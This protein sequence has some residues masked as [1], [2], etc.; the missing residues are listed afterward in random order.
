MLV[1]VRLTLYNIVAGL[2][3]GPTLNLRE[4]SLEEMSI[5]RKLTTVCCAAV[6]ALGL[7]ACSSSNNDTQMG[8][9]KPP[10]PPAD[11]TLLFA[12]AQDAGDAAMGAGDD[13]TAAEKAAMDNTDEYDTMRVAGDSSVAM[14]NARA[15]LDAQ[16]D[17]GQ[18]VMDAQT[19]LVDANQAK[20][21]AEDIDDEHPQKA[22]LDA[23]I[24]EA[25]AAADKAL[26]AATDIHDGDIVND[27]V[28]GVTGGED[29]DPPGTARSIANK[30]GMD[31]AMAL[32]PNA[33]G[34]GARLMADEEM[35]PVEED[36]V[37]EALMVMMDDRVGMTWAEIVG[38]TVKMRIAKD[39][40]NTNEVDA[41]S[42]AGMTLA[43]TRD[44]TD[45][46]MKEANGVQVGAAY[47]GI[48]GTAFCVGSNC[49][50][51]ADAD[52]GRKFTG[53]WYFT[54]A[55]PMQ[56]YLKNADGVYGPETLFVSFGHWL[57]V[58]EAAGDEWTVHT[59]A[60]STAAT[61][62]TVALSDDLDDSATYNG[63]AAGM[64]VY[65]TDN[66]AG[67]GQDINS[68]R[69]TAD[70]TLN[71]EFGIATRTAAMIGGTIDGFDGGYAAND[72]WSVRLVEVELK[73]DG[74]P[75][76]GK[77]VTASDDGVWSAA[78]YGGD[79]AA[80]PAGV[81]GTF[82]AH[83]LDGHAAGAYATR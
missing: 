30:V 39:A 24:V 60:T 62:Y 36:E 58:D 80:R 75:S 1:G 70:V 8:N 61:L 50:V 46:Q 47:K 13:A 31:I 45:A 59:F 64:S 10:P 71:A 53:D 17:A 48:D 40:D 33:D 4:E 76:T 51:E 74:A 26:K 18:A 68:G 49:V 79:A 65:K 2:V 72:E 27:A 41:A 28:D 9:G 34:G 6:L 66:A 81:F 11:L 56:V 29:A 38:D 23:A 3:S 82:N 73:A 44:V 12:A 83:F 52:G 69:F 5:H 14:K 32:L 42:I 55:M 20:M 77:T 78:A 21:D 7:A 54:P 35:A 67:D 15:I 43:S 63:K 37:P 16:D 25:I 57:T 22:S 19:A